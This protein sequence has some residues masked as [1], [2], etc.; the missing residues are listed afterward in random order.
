M[1]TISTISKIHC[2]LVGLSLSIITVPLYAKKH[3]PI[4][5]NQPI[6]V[7]IAPIQFS[8]VPIYIDALGSLTAEE[9][10]TISADVNGRIEHIFF[11]NGQ[12]VGKNMPIIQLNNSVEQANYNIAVTALNLSRST[13]ARYNLLP[14]GTESKEDLAKQQAEIDSNQATVQ[15]QQALLNQKTVTAPFDGTLGN[16]LFQV[17][18]YVTAGTP[19]VTLENNNNL[20]VN[21]SV[22]Q[23]QSA[24]LNTNQQVKF[25]VDAYPDKTFYG[26]VTFISPSV[27]TTTRTI[28]IQ[29]L[30]DN[31]KNLLSAGMFTHVL[32]QIGTTSHAMLVPDEAISADIKGYYV[33][34][35]IQNRAIKTYITTGTSIKNLVEV[36]SGLNSQDMIIISGIQKLQDGSNITVI[37]ASNLKKN[38]T[39]LMQ[40]SSK[41]GAS[42]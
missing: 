29:A 12:Q 10:V 30:F 38:N 9:T 36:T 26:T 17:G 27:N 32:Q 25:T 18:D 2:I 41:A 14:P 8:D 4:D 28:A 3:L 40:K 7:Q 33:Y 42:R 37:D 22:P 5:L 6:V 34:L 39:S 20:L 11:S 19:M 15:L 24:L 35:D 16:F 1:A 21:F 31:K 13:L 23:S